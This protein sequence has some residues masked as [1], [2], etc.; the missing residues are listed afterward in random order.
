MDTTLIHNAVEIANMPDSMVVSVPDTIVVTQNAAESTFMCMPIEVAAIVIPTLATV[1]SIL[2]PLVVL[3]SGWYH[4]RCKKQKERQQETE[5][6]RN[7]IFTW[8][9]QLRPSL[10]GLNKNIVEFVGRINNNQYISN[11]KLIYQPSMVDKLDALTVSNVVKYLVLNSSAEGE[12]KRSACAYTIVAEI[13]KIRFCEEQILKS[14]E[15]YQRY[16]E[17]IMSDWNTLLVSIGRQKDDGPAIDAEIAFF[18]ELR[19][20]KV[21]QFQDSDG[22]FKE[23]IVPD[24]FRKYIQPMMD[25]IRLAPVFTPGAERSN[26]LTN[27]IRMFVHV[28]DRWKAINESYESLFSNY[29]MACM[30]SFERLTGAIKY[31]KENTKAIK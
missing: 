20:I 12:D 19:R 26:R 21:R 2:I 24:T 4:E 3:V 22:T 1:L 11:A 15:K 14:Y 10:T 8:F 17:G 16:S 9:E 29:G 30:Y 7:T 23:P 18:T 31:F 28:Y 13:G 25:A 27:D 5:D 6:Y